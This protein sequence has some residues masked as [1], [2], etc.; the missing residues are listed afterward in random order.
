M[1]FKRQSV[2]F[3][4][5]LGDVGYQHSETRL[6]GT[7]WEYW[8]GRYT[9]PGQIVDERILYVKS[10]CGWEELQFALDKIRKEDRPR[11]FYVVLQ[12]TARS[13]RDDID[14]IRSMANNK[15]VYSVSGFLFQAVKRAVTRR[16]EIDPVRHFVQ[17]SVIF[18]PEETR[19]PSLQAVLRWLRGGQGTG[20][21]VAVL[22]APA[23]SGKTSL[24]REAFRGLSATDKDVRIPLLVEREVWKD[25]LRSERVDLIDVWRSSMSYWYPGA[26]LGYDQLERCLSLG[27]IC[28]IFDGLDE[29]CTAFPLEINPDDTVRSL[30]TLFEGGGGG[31]RLLLT[32]R[33]SFWTENISPAIQSQVLQVDLCPFD[34]LQIRSFL[35]KR[36]EGDAEAEERALRVLHRI[37]SATGRGERATCAEGWSENVAANDVVGGHIEQVPYVAVLAAESADTEQPERLARFGKLFSEPDP[38]RGLLLAICERERERQKLTLTAEEQVEL[39]SELVA[40]FEGSVYHRDELQLC[41]ETRGYR[42]AQLR[43]LRSHWFLSARPGERYVFQYPFI[44]DY[45]MARVF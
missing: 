4:S 14:R 8:N 19:Q 42:K 2:D 27:A 1:P 20:P 34:D 10:D 44:E 36:F 16:Q 43:K 12:N 21:N 17:Q 39:F 13:F 32:S 26:I 22:L 28:P 24:A 40:E 9:T 11:N 35:K 3:R 38:V 5:V 15:Q 45:L 37:G 31:G 18:P 6:S 29:L 30:L 23:A 25:L 7:N 41:G 33:A